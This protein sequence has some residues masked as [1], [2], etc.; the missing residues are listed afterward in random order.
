MSC[1]RFVRSRDPVHQVLQGLSLDTPST[2]R[3]KEAPTF[4]GAS[5]VMTMQAL[6][7]KWSS[8]VHELQQK[9][10]IAVHNSID[11]LDGA[12]AIK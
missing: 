9:H 7:L 8:V 6:R 10:R 4:T 2:M 12:L 1:L 3:D 5:S 11:A